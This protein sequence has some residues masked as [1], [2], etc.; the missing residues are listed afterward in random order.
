MVNK[1]SLTVVTVNRQT[2]GPMKGS[3]ARLL[4]WRP[5][6]AEGTDETGA[7]T[8]PAPGVVGIDRQTLRAA[9]QASEV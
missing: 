8:R 3:L 4:S 1:Y 5:R 2:A 6:G 9:A 7:V